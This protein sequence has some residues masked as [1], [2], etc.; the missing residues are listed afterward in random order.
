MLVVCHCY[1]K[2]WEEHALEQC[3]EM[4]Q[5]AFDYFPSE[6]KYILISG[7][8]VQTFLYFVFFATFQ[9]LLSIQ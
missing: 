9:S 5:H 3:V 1:N 2:G 6:K 7:N 4:K 8:G